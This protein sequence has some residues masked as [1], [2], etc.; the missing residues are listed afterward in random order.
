[1]PP[2]IPEIDR[3]LNQDDFVRNPRDRI[4]YDI[5]AITALVPRLI[6][7]NFLGRFENNRLGNDFPEIVLV[8]FGGLYT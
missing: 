3:S 5:C 4:G 2:N 8:K 1:M 6:G 7:N